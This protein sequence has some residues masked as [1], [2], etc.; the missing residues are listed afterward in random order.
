MRTRIGWLIPLIFA[1]VA[2]LATTSAA[3]DV[4]V[5]KIV[6]FKE[7]VAP[8]AKQSAVR[9]A[10]GKQLK[11]LKL[12]NAEAAELTPASAASLASQSD[13]VRIIDDRLAQ[14]HT[15]DASRATAIP[16]KTD[17]PSK[18][19]GNNKNKDKDKDKDKDKNK[20]DKK[21]PK[22]QIE[23]WGVSRINAPEAWDVSKGQNV[24]VAV[25]DS[26][27]DLKHP[28]LKVA[29]GVNQVQSA[30]SYDDDR[31]HGTH[32]AGIIAA[33]DNGSGVVGV[34]PDIE[35][36][37]VKVMDKHGRGWWS[38][39]FAGLE[40]CVDNGIQVANLSFGSAE[41]DETYEEVIYNS[42]KAGVV[43]V[44]SAGNRG[45][46]PDTV[47]YPARYPGVIAVSAIDPTD[48]I[49][50]F[51]S[52]GPHV[53]LA[54]PGVDI[55]STYTGPKYQIMSGTSM[56]APHVTAVAA[57]RMKFDPDRSPDHIAAVLKENATKL[58]G[59]TSDQQGTGLVDAYKVVTAP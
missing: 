52:N 10:G 32:I 19:N 29:G 2:L 16:G 7:G 39:I 25:L 11:S 1:I 20:K 14:E 38:D 48:N 44:A 4:P 41:Y 42:Y 43:L 36:Y 9:K 6:V 23:P 57:L 30:K 51:S 50:S 8:P 28:D 55:Q 34:G 18:N 24:K 26:G 56:A 17:D 47:Q 13:V 54:A 46:G 15:V 27:I 37:A 45:P 49:A 53:D 35:L 33:L 5:R 31:G 21:N 3:A 58:P 40:W 12:V 22:D 59:L